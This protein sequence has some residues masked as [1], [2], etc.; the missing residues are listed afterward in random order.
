MPQSKSAAK[1]IQ[2]QEAKHLRK[3][4]EHKVDYRQPYPEESSKYLT[5][6]E[7]E[8]AK[9]EGWSRFAAKNAK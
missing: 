7:L 3:K 1:V 2:W 8:R 5:P 6:M 4:S 9:E